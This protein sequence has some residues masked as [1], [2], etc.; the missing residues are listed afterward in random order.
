VP[1]IHLTLCLAKRSIGSLGGLKSE[2][3]RRETGKE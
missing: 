2:V 1:S 3:V